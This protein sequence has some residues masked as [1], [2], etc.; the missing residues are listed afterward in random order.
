MALLLACKNEAY[1]VEARTSTN[2]RF[3]FVYRSNWN[4]RFRS[5]MKLSPRLSNSINTRQHSSIAAFRH[6][7]HLTAVL[8]RRLRRSPTKKCALG[9]KACRQLL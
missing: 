2:C 8:T 5:L 4:S 1:R 9:N 3:R 7:F 6:A